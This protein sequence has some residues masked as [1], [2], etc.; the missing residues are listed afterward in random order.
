M[1]S[2]N[3][4]NSYIKNFLI[5]ININIKKIIRNPLIFYIE[6]YNDLY[7]KVIMEK[8]YLV[9]FIMF[10]LIIVFTWID[11]IKP[12]TDEEIEN[13]QSRQTPSVF[14]QFFQ[15]FKNKLAQRK[16][17]N[18]TQETFN[19]GQQSPPT[20][21]Y[22]DFQAWGGRLI[23]DPESARI[24]S[25]LRFGCKNDNYEEDDIGFETVCS[26]PTHHNNPYAVMARAIGY[27]RIN[28]STL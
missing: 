27:P 12:I 18:A 3:K 7:K 28:L 2:R 17:L 23:P 16:Q 19:I 11:K 21:G 8:I 10:I 6:L 14:S 24:P 26:V 20:L 9:I 22:D 25:E 15:I 13:K 1:L 4:L 5:N